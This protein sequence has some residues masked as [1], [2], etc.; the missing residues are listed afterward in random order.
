MALF[1]TR[2]EKFNLEEEIKCLQILN[3]TKTTKLPLIGHVARN[4]ICVS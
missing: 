1:Y 4:E 3:T 2:S